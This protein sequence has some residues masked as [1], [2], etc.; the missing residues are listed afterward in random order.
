VF[1]EAL[2]NKIKAD[3]CNVEILTE[4][5]KD[6]EASLD[7]RADYAGKVVE[8]WI[9]LKKAQLLRF[10]CQNWRW[11][12]GTKVTNPPAAC[13]DEKTYKWLSEEAERSF[14][15]ALQ[16]HSSPE[17]FPLIEKHRKLVRIVDRKTG[18]AR[19]I[20]DADIIKMKPGDFSQVDLD[21]DGINDALGEY[22]KEDIQRRKQVIELLK[23]ESGGQ[24]VPGDLSSAV[25]DYLY[26]SGAVRDV[27]IKHELAVRHL[28]TG[29]VEPKSTIAGCIMAWN[30]P[31]LIGSTIEFVGGSLVGGGVIAGGAKLLMPLV[32]SSRL[33]TGTLGVLANVHRANY[34]SSVI[35]GM[36]DSSQ[37]VY[38]EC[39]SNIGKTARADRWTNNGLADMGIPE[40]LRKKYLA[41]RLMNTLIPEAATPTCQ[42]I[43]AKDREGYI[44]RDYEANCLQVALMSMLNF[45]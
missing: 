39:L 40:T 3:Q 1:H 2:Q 44:R 32:K 18:K 43:A 12:R 14:E 17:I 19:P 16:T 8:G 45:F 26:E 23:S 38:K 5:S 7:L 4:M 9:G 6:E 10:I 24:G 33:L 30:E 20:E 34:V 35:V 15:H 13:R 28:D 31:T 29:R 21:V 22:F 42:Q 11:G 37:Q 25:Q 41:F 27:L 36:T